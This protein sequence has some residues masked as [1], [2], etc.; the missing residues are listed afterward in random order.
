MADALLSPAAGGAMLAV[1]A[2]SVAYSVAKV[3]KD[4]LCEKKVPVMAITGAFVFAAQMINFTIPATG[5]SGHIGGGILLASILGGF[6]ALLSITAVLVIQALFFADGGLL[7][8]GC[9]IFN[10]GVIPCLVVYPIL[11]RPFIKKK[12]SYGRITAASV[13]SVVIALQLGAFAVVLETLA[14]G[15]TELPFG[16]FAALMQPIHL[17]IGI[18]EGVIT[19]AVVTFVYRMRP[20]II[21]STLTGSAIR[22]TA[23]IKK[24]L[25]SIMVIT[26]V[27]GGGLSLLASSNPDGL[28]WAIEK[29]AG[30][31]ELTAEGSIYETAEKVQN[32]TAFMPDYD[33]KNADESSSGTGTSVAG[34]VG[35]ILTFA[36]A[37]AAGFVISRIKRTKAAA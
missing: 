10:L 37:G 20:E 15:K 11:F 16:A 1:S 33:F 3:K 4:E 25:I 36:L 6:P 19:A 5:S 23:N 35:G 26:L 24:V 30:D 32:S 13:I 22:N 12:I 8:L 28:E 14:S 27:V 31:A 7:A 2:A 9:N 29:T 17:A 34:I 18:A 21:D